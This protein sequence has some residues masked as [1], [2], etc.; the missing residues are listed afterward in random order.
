MK[1]YI[2]CVCVFLSGSLPH[3]LQFHDAAACYKAWGFIRHSESCV[4]AE[5]IRCEIDSYVPANRFIRQIIEVNSM[6]LA[7]HCHCAA[8]APSLCHAI[9][10]LSLRCHCAVTVPFLCVQ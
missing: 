4:K 9:T 10:V 8:T 3:S 2:A 1:Y 6:G 5:R 7:L